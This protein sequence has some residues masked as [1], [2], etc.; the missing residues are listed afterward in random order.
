[1]VLATDPEIGLELLKVRFDSGKT[2]IVIPSDNKVVIDFLQK[3]GYQL[4]LTLPRMIL[5]NEVNWRPDSVFNRAAGY[6]G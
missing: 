3:E 2:K 1:M 6:C 4:D 5:G